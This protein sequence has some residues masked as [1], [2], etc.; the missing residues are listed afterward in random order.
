[1]RRWLEREEDGERL[2][3]RGHHRQIAASGHALWIL[4]IALHQ[5]ASS[6]RG[7]RR[8]DDDGERS[9]TISRATILH[10]DRA[11]R[12][13]DHLHRSLPDVV[14]PCGEAILASFVPAILT[15]KPCSS[16]CGLGGQLKSGLARRSRHVERAWA[17]PTFNLPVGERQSR[18][19][20]QVRAKDQDSDWLLFASY[21]L[22]SSSIPPRG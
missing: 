9:R 8:I 18:R 13:D 14:N 21:I 20:T 4:L 15:R 16:L 17:E 11:S 7:V 3:S 12:K 10:R 19:P 22:P 5:L 2:L 1:M 6:P